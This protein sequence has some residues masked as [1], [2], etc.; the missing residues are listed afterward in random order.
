MV[1]SQPAACSD[2]PE[3]NAMASCGVECAGGT[4]LQTEGSCQ[5]PRR[6]AKRNTPART[7]KRRCVPSSLVGTSGPQKHTHSS[8]APSPWPSS[9][10]PHFDR[11]QSS[12]PTSGPSTKRESRPVLAAAE[13]PAIRAAYAAVRGKERLSL[14]TAR[15]VASPGIDAACAYVFQV[16][17]LPMVL[18][19]IHTGMPRRSSCLVMKFAQRRCSLCDRSS[20]GNPCARACSDHDSPLWAACSARSRRWLPR[21]SQSARSDLSEARSLSLP[22]TRFARRT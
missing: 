16:L 15:S 17:T 22:F 6:K 18:S 12:E 19:L 11:P 7:R 2:S 14:A 4:R 8:D 1:G 20:I 13:T 5:T 10:S 21:P 3:L 9:S